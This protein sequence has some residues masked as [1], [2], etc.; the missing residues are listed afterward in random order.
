[1]TNNTMKKFLRM[2]GIVWAVAL[3]VLVFAIMLLKID[4]VLE[5]LSSTPVVAVICI[6][7]GLAAG[8][9]AGTIVCF[10]CT[11][12]LMEVKD[13]EIKKLQT[14]LGKLKS[15]YDEACNTLSCIYTQKQD[16]TAKSDNDRGNQIINQILDLSED[17]K[18]S[19]EENTKEIPDIQRDDFEDIESSTESETD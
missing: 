10:L 18:E 8:F 1:M 19:P 3:T 14:K 17:S 5:I 6:I 2:L 13:A 16:N 11:S 4:L 7:F 15:D 12:K 9:I